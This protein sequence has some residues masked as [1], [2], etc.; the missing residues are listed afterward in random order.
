MWC[1]RLTRL[2]AESDQHLLLQG[3]E[4]YGADFL[5]HALAHKKLAWVYLERPDALDVISQGNALATAVNNCLGSAFLPLALP[6]GYHVESLKAHPALLEE[7]V[8][9]VSRAERAPALSEALLSLP[10]QQCRVVLD[11][12]GLLSIDTQKSRV[13]LSSRLGLS[14]EE[15]QQEAPDLSAEA[16]N[17]LW[18]ITDG[19]YLDFL[20]GLHRLTGELA[21]EIPTPRGATRRPLGEEV[22]VDPAVFLDVLLL[23]RRFIEALDVACRRVPHRVREII[24]D[25][26]PAYQ[27][28][29]LGER[30]YLL[31]RSLDDEYLADKTVLE[32]LLVAAAHAGQLS[33]VLPLVEA[34][35]QTPGP[36]ELRARYIG[37]IRDPEHR[38][39]TAERLAS[40]FATPLSLFQWGRLHPDP[41]EGVLIL[42]QAVQLAEDV[43]RPYDAVRNA[44]ALAE[45]LVHTG[46]FSEAL[47]WGEWALR[48]FDAHGLAD[49]QRR[50]RLVNNWAYARMITDQLA[51]LDSELWAYQAQLEGVLPDMALLFRSTLAELELV[52][53]QPDK[54]T[55]LARSNVWQCSRRWLG[56]YVVTLVRALL[57]Q[58]NIDEA[59]KEARL[60]QTVTQDQP[61][62]GAARLALGMA[63]AFSKPADAVSLLEPVMQDEREPAERRCAATLYYLLATGEGFHSLPA[64]VQGLFR[65][66]KRSGLRLYSGPENRFRTIWGQILTNETA[67]RLNILGRREV[68]LHGEQQE[69]TPFLLELLTV[70]ALSPQGLS[71][72]QLHARLYPE[73]EDKL[74]SLKVNLSRL[75]KFVPIS[76]VPYQITLDYSVDALELEALVK[77]SRLREALSLY[78]GPL[79]ADSSVPFIEE[80]R[81]FFDELLRQAA[82]KSNDPEV[83]FTFAQQADDLE[84]WEAAVPVLERLNDPRLALARAM[85]NRL[86][87]EYELTTY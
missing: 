61:F 80:R 32:W 79:L 51:G 49:G 6:F 46:A 28:Q 27:D 42:R 66:V 56:K 64:Q 65:D 55:E 39:Q 31:L 11:W 57:E 76:S 86:A 38:Y 40:T 21:P 59:L 18:R 48:T 16:V 68:W 52:L 83:L 36:S 20:T 78:Q 9:A 26:G 74:A 4:A 43:G 67:L 44:G 81:G 30:L 60:A 71:L 47:G 7:M 5:F 77:T 19:A 3:G 14:F 22:M 35:L 29:G 84:L 12:Q 17:H 50:L 82:L 85:V 10:A 41:D 25:A 23:Q 69:L 2:V 75:R 45:R 54:A 33:S 34:C 62:Y 70:L 87:K 8:I 15:A 63:L 58:E 73:Q 53:G 1:Q 13:V 72:E 37:V 24:T